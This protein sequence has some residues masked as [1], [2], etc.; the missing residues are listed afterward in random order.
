MEEK[1]SIKISLSTVLLI[2]ALVLIV[3]LCIFIYKLYNE[4]IIAN[5]NSLE[6]QTQV[7]T[8]NETITV[9]QGKID[10]ISETI[11]SNTS[12]ENNNGNI[13][14]IETTYSADTSFTVEQVKQA[15]QRY[16]NLVSYNTSSPST[17]L[18]ELDFI[19]Q[20]SNEVAKKE[21]YLK[22]NVKFAQFKDTML[23]YVTEK[24]Y[25][26]V[27]ANSFIDE[28]GYLCYFDGGASGVSYEVKNVTKQVDKKY[29]AKVE[30][31]QETAKEDVTF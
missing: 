16:L 27:F 10:S 21:G 3:I 18:F 17:L 30:W 22:T 2:L 4:K 24:C 23:K 15:F 31:S 12:I 28:N 20:H 5:Q 1:N 26:N 25:D 9:L 8:L 7:N 13:S 11:N 19:N 6:L 29:I 14:N